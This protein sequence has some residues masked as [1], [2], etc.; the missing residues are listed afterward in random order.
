M[1]SLRTWTTAMPTAVMVGVSL[2]LTVTL[3]T[4]LTCRGVALTLWARS[5]RTT[6]S[7]ALLTSIAGAVPTTAVSHIALVASALLATSSA[8]GAGVG[9]VGGL[10]AET[11]RQRQFLDALLNQF[12][13]APE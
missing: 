8:T 4:L 13:Y 5:A 9:I 10:L 3:G 1:T 7:A 12:L 11:L 2:L 6:V